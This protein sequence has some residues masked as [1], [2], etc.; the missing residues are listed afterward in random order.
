MKKNAIFILLLFS[1][2]FSN[3]KAQ[4][5]DNKWVFG[6]HLAS[7]LY[8]DADGKVVGGAFASQLPR[9][10]LAMYFKKGFT[11][12]GGLGLS[13]I[14]DQKYNTFDGAIRYDFGKDAENSVPYILLGGSFI[15]APNLTPT[16]NFG[17][18][19]TFWVFPRYGLNFQLMYKYSENRFTSQRSHFYPSAGIVYSFKPRNL[20]QRLWDRKH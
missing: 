15:Y 5:T 17:V 13:T 2:V 9:F 4:S 12:E 8:Q 14:D 11:L 19:N 10:T 18:G 7:A 6:A 20:N 16:L 3:L 1:F